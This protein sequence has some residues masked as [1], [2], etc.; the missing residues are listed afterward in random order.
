MS[1][2][3][4]ILDAK[5]MILTEDKLVD[6]IESQGGM[7]ITRRT[8]NLG[9]FDFVDF[10]TLPPIMFV[11][12]TGYQ[13]LLQYFFTQTIHKFTQPAVVIIVETDLVALDPSWL[14]NPKVKHCF[15]WNKPFSHPKLSAIPIGLNYRR[16]Y[17]GLEEWLYQTTASTS[18][19][20]EP[21]KWL[22]MNYS[23]DTNP[24][25]REL[26]QKAST[27]WSEFCT[28]I[29]PIPPRKSYDIPSHIEGT[30]RIDETDPRCYDEWRNYRFVLSPPGAGI[31]CH[32]TWEAIAVGCIPIVISSNL[33]E[34]YTD[35]PVV[36]VDS[37]DQ[38]TAEYL[39][40][41]YAIIDK[42]RK[43]SEDGPPYKLDRITLEYWTERI[44]NVSQYPQKIHFITYGNDRFAESKARL[45]KEAHEFGEFA[46]IQGYG[47]ENLSPEFHQSY[48]SIMEQPRGGGYW[49]WRPVII[50]DALSMINEDDILIYLDAG[51]SLNPRGKERFFEYIDLLN[52]SPEKYGTL[53]FQMSGNCGPGN[54]EIEK[55]W[56]TR[57]IFEHFEVDP[58]GEIANS[59]QYWAGGVIMKKNAN[60][61]KYMEVFL[62]TVLTKPLLCTDCYNN[63]YQIP[64][65]RDNRH[66]QSITSVLR[67]KM[68]SVVIDGDESWMLPFGEGESLKYPF[69]ATRIKR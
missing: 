24:Q 1:N 44:G 33:N 42:R 22:C 37:W 39:E 8:M 61:R 11:G 54:L 66:E 31:D 16:Q 20:P 58:N 69:W 38:I 25:R 21:S 10:N 51:S 6:W 45:L 18:P 5:K 52:N 60:L 7:L 47:P 62:S 59:G 53:A 23:P 13:H 19:T 3:V 50:Q 56:T 55:R 9:K 63:N 48:K 49:I 4:N 68:G 35:L 34:L 14:N 30:L 46:S 17:A 29:E 43:T 26:I 67:K 32:R 2:T 41:Q 40:E 28:I 15:T 64:E 36:V 27:E 65:F 57:E 12:I